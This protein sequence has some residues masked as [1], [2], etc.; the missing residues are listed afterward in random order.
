[1]NTQMADEMIDFFTRLLSKVSIWLMSEPIV[2][3]TACFLGLAVIGVI[4]RLWHITR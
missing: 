1:M 3:F 4:N 2:Y